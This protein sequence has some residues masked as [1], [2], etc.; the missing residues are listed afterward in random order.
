[1]AATD[2]S[3]GPRVWPRRRIVLL[4]DMKAPRFSSGAALLRSEK[5]GGRS[6]LW[7]TPKITVGTRSLPVM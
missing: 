1:M 2:M 4:M 6:R 7:A 5:A 3:T